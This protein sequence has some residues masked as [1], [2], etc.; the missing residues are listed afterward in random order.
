M[1][2]TCAFF[3]HRDAPWEV[4]P[5]LC[6]SIRRLIEEEGC[7]RFLV[8]HNGTFDRMV[9]RAL[10]EARVLHPHIDV[11][12]VMA[13][14]PTEREGWEYGRDACLPEGLER[15]PR[16]FSIPWRNK[17]MIRRSRF[18]VTYVRG[19]V[20]GAAQARH[21]ARRQGRTLITLVR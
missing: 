12:V 8:G 7:R 13:F 6:E 17:W 4:Y 14:L 18:V 21:Y 5:R 1:E 15:V 2:A 16:R 9:Y 3:G 11:C 10:C 20:G 19:E